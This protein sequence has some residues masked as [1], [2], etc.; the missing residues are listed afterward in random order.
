MNLTIVAKLLLSLLFVISTFAKA[1]V[2]IELNS[3]KVSVNSDN[4]RLVRTHLTPK[5][6]KLK[7]NVPMRQTVCGLYDT[8]YITGRHPSCGY[9][10]RVR[11]T[12]CR[13][14]CTK[15]RV[16]GPNSSPNCRPACVRYQQ[17]CD[18]RRERVMNICTYPETYCARRDVVNAGSK[19]DKVTLKFKNVAELRPGEV[20][21]F[22]LNA[23]QARV[24]SGNIKYDLRAERSIEDYIIKVREFFG[25]RIIIKGN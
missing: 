1:Q 21:V 5:K 6:V 25:D 14:T 4:V 11:R 19:R 9:T 22:T 24:D 15:R 10:T 16:C 17:T 20:E 13:R 18:I 7:V 3:E 12:N 2:G 8:R 23:R